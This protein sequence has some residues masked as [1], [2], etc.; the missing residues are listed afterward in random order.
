M[1][2]VIEVVL[3]SAHVVRTPQRS[4][5]GQDI[6]T[7]I[8]SLAQWCGHFQI[9]CSANHTVQD[10]VIHRILQLT[11]KQVFDEHPTFEETI[12]DIVLLQCRKAASVD[13]ISSKK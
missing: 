4:S 12:E 1:Y 10:T 8:T 5:V 3:W 6:H 13:G 7:D 11:L 2:E 9:I